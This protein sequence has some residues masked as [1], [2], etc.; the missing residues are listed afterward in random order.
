MLFSCWSCAA[1][2]C[3]HAGLASKAYTLQHP[4]LFPCCSRAA[5]V[6]LP[7]CSRAGPVLLPCCS[8]VAPVLLSSCSRAALVL[9]SCCSR[10]VLVLFSCRSRAALVLS[11]CCYRAVLVLF[12]YAICRFELASSFMLSYSWQAPAAN[13]QP[14]ISDSRIRGSQRAPAK[15]KPALPNVG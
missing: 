2:C 8:R 5:P 13:R 3:S 12:S 4:V 14:R 6:L 9:L 10:A 7:C 1:P 15:C 11:S